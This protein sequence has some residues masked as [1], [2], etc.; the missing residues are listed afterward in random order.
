MN[1][2]K[3]ERIRKR[4]RKEKRWKGLRIGNEGEEAKDREGSRDR[5]IG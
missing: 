5:K 2:G 1:R 4:E 3:R